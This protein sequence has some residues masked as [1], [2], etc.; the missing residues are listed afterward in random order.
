MEF[1]RLG[2]CP[3]FFLAN[4]VAQSLG[5]KARMVIYIMVFCCAKVWG[6]LAFPT[7]SMG[8]TQIGDLY[9]LLSTSVLEFILF[10]IGK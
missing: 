3:H 5:F 1:G 8:M 7:G 2:P 10:Y 9:H 4:S 6:P